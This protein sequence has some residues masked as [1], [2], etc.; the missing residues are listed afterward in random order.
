MAQKKQSFVSD[1]YDGVFEGTGFEVVVF[2]HP[3]N[4][5][6]ELLALGK[7]GL[8]DIGSSSVGDIAHNVVKISDGDM[9]VGLV[10]TKR[11]WLPHQALPASQQARSERE[12]SMT[13]AIFGG[14]RKYRS[15][16][17]LIAFGQSEG[18]ITAADGMSAAVDYATT[19]D[20]DIGDALLAD[21]MD[22]RKG[23]VTIDS[24]VHDQ[25][26]S[27]GQL[28]FELGGL[29]ANCVPDLIKMGFKE[30][31]RMGV[32]FLKHGLSPFEGLFL[33]GEVEYL[34]TLDE[35]PV[36]N[37]LRD[38]GVP[39]IHT[40]RTQ[41]FVPGA[42]FLSEYN[43]VEEGRH[44]TSLHGEGSLSVAGR[45]VEFAQLVSEEDRLRSIQ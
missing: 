43:F 28:L 36:V 34:S 20:I 30:R 6:P 45:I 9:A 27:K 37:K 32:D 35:R 24:P 10:R 3:G 21:F 38:K 41:D 15:L 31:F 42:E 16:S 40:S 17:T 4:K 25:I 8:G 44:L 7:G 11:P 13:G 26:E 18:G 19:A 14:V 5:S 12:R 22:L 39:V 2:R 33:L 1:Q 23:V 29:A